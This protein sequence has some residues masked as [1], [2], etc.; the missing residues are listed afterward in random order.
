M[1]GLVTTKKQRATLGYRA[2]KQ[3]S[4]HNSLKM[5]EKT[6]ATKT[7]RKKKERKMAAVLLGMSWAALGG[8]THVSA[9][10]TGKREGTD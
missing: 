4:E 10:V 1:C 5:G 9:E 3:Y 2:R 7:R 8:W 6:E